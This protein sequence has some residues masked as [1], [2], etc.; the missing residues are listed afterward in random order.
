MYENGEQINLFF[1]YGN[2]QRD[3]FL[4]GKKFYYEKALLKSY[5]CPQHA[6]LISEEKKKKH[7]TNYVCIKAWIE[8][9]KSSVLKNS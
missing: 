1:S 4:L 9:M 5:Q 3:N 6:R 8:K 7:K 2:N